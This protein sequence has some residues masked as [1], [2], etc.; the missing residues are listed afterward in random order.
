MNWLARLKNTAVPPEA[1]ATEPTKPE[2]HSQK[3]GFVGFVAPIPAHIQKTGGDRAAANDTP[4]PAPA[5]TAG[6][7]KTT[8]DRFRAASLA[9][10]AVIQAA[11]MAADPD[12]WTWPHS[13]AMNTAEIDTFTARLCRFTDKGLIVAFAETLA[14]KLVI[15]DREGDDRRLCLE[16]Q[17]LGGYA[18]GS[19]RC[20]AWQRAGMDM[21][22]ADSRLASDEVTTLR[23]CDEFT[24]E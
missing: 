2:P 11:D 10:D 15:R 8:A 18:S 13:D 24:G 20:G 23:R 22:V 4:D 14:D 21:Q 1:E 19:W 12:R 9:L 3:G 6:A 16:C 17:H 5:T 7:P